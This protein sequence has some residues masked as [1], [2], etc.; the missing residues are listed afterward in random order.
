M[1]LCFVTGGV[2]SGK[3]A[4]A[5]TLC[6][7]GRGEVVYLA[8]CDPTDEEM[9][10]R[11]ANHRLRRPTHWEVKEEAHFL[12]DAIAGIPAVK[13]I[14]LDSVTAW[15]SNRLER[16]ACES[17][18]GIDGQQTAIERIAEE[19]EAWLTLIKTRNA[20]VVTDE[21]GLGGVAMH[22][23]TRQFQDALGTVNQMVAKRADEVWLVVSGI[24]WKVKG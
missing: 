1:G 11:I 19:A 13:T 15:V 23:V 6:E 24:P 17:G 10:A 18:Q 3:S 21:V 9:K 14:L 4:F 12:A 8:T 5:E 2:R 22:P 16:W 20:V 7:R